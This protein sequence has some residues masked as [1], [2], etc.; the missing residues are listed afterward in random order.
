MNVAPRSSAAMAY[1]ELAGNGHFRGLSSSLSSCDQRAGI[2][3]DVDR[4]LGRGDVDDDQMG[5]LLLAAER[6]HIVLK[7]LDRLAGRFSQRL[8]RRLGEFRDR[9]ADVVNRAGPEILFDLFEFAFALPKDVGRDG[10]AFG[11]HPHRFVVQPA[12]ADVVPADDQVLPIEQLER[13]E[14]RQGADQPDFADQ[15][16]FQSDQA[17]ERRGGDAPFGAD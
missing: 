16:F 17:G 5:Q 7:P 11:V 2:A 12:V 8:H 13:G 1:S 14:L 9:R 6:I 3:C 10:P 4:R 15:P